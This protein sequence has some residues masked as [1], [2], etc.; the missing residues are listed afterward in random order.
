LAQVSARKIERH[1][2]PWA[3]YCGIARSPCRSGDRFSPSGVRISPTPSRE[4][5]A[6]FS[7]LVDPQRIVSLDPWDIFGRDHFATE[8][9][10]GIDVRPSIAIH[11]RFALIWPE[12]QAAIEGRF[13]SSKTARVVHENVKRLRGSRSRSTRLVS[14]R[15]WRTLH[16]TR[17]S[18]PTS[19]SND[20]RHVPDWWTRPICRFFCRRI[21]ARHLLFGTCQTAGPPHPETC[22][23]A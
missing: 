1:R 16:D 23:V 2:D 19:C 8:I 22:R 9:A 20:R 15:A 17:T 3:V 18:A 13:G 6:P 5:I 21:A 14:G 7:Q 11:A 10:D 12:L 4:T